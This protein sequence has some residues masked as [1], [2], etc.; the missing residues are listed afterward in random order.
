MAWTA[1][2]T[3]VAGEI[4]TAAIGNTHWRDNLLDLADGSWGRDVQF[5]ATLANIS[6]PLSGAF[7]N[8]TG[9]TFTTVTGGVYAID[10]HM[11]INN[12]S[13]SAPGWRS[14]WS[15]TGTGKMSSGQTGADITVVNP[16]YTGSYTAHAITGATSSPSDEGTGFGTPA[17]T[18]LIA[19]VSATF[20]CTG[21]GAVQMRH[22][23]AVSNASFVSRVEHG[24]RMRVERIA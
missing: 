17:A 12:A 24:S 14:G 19:R 16:A 23:Q 8:I 6:T 5:A 4:V 2:R 1:P 9:F 18:P 10:C 11:F 20:E 15:W 7:G 3:W 22:A 21:G 13:S